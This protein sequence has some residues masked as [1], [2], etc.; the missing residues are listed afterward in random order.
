MFM[1]ILHWLL[2]HSVVL[3]GG[4]FLLLVATVYWPGRK[5]RFQC[6]AMIGGREGLRHRPAH[7]RA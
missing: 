4:V 3:V 5:E 7:H 2:D 6:D 1:T